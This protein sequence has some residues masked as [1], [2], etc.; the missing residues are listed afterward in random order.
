MENRLRPCKEA[1]DA[2]K[3]AFIGLLCFGFILGPMAIFKAVEAKKLMRDD[4]T[5]LG[6]GKSTAAL[7][8]GIFALALWLMSL[9]SRLS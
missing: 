7:V 9:V 6:S 1:A 8:V 4:P 5:L 3:F 2:L